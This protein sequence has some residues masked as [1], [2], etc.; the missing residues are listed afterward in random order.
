L[1]TNHSLMAHSCK[2]RASL[3]R[4]VDLPR[5]QDR[6]DDAE[7]DILWRCSFLQSHSPLSQ[8][9]NPYSIELLMIIN[10]QLLC[11]A[12]TRSRVNIPPRTFIPAPSPISTQHNNKLEILSLSLCKL[13]LKCIDLMKKVFPSHREI[14]FANEFTSTASERDSAH[15]QCENKFLI[16]VENGER[17]TVQ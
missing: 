1:S 3:R 9:S 14:F 4:C 17:T 10:A 6:R 7:I 2:E 13:M 11:C 5:R 8:P 12:K 16:K 15:V